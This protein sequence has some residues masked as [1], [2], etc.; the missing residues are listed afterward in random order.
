MH[1][2]SGRYAPSPEDAVT[3]WR[4]HQKMP[5]NAVKLQATGSALLLLVFGVLA[6]VSDFPEIM[7]VG[8]TIAPIFFIIP[9]LQDRSARRY[10]AH[11]KTE[12]VLFEISPLG[13]SYTAPTWS[14]H[15]DWVVVKRARVDQRGLIIY[16]GESSFSFLPARAFQPEFLPHEL[17]SFLAAQLKTTQ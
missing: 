13:I 10:A 7:V 6:L 4:M 1:R 8:V 14:S 9:W 11:Q 17:K 2:F 5:V 3:A 12:E 15:H 16:T